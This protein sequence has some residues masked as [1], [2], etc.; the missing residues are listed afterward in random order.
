[1]KKAGIDQMKDYRGLRRGRLLRWLSVFLAISVTVTLLSGQIA[2][3]YGDE[4][5]N[6]YVLADEGS[7]EDVTI[8][9]GKEEDQSIR[10]HVNPGSGEEESDSPEGPDS[11]MADATGLKAVE[12]GDLVTISPADGSLLPEDA[13][14]S[15]EILSGRAENKAVKKVE[16]ATGVEPAA[17]TDHQAGSS[18]QDRKEEEAVG[19]KSG[20]NGNPVPG[21]CGRGTV[22]GRI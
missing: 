5:E 8:H 2:S 16:E 14:A 4:P 12:A 13:E 11:E 15:A 22:S 1:M 10:V 21:E 9:F 20:G 3:F 17:Q 6:D 7:G 19:A 18:A